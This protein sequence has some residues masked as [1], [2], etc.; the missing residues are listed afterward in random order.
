VFTSDRLPAASI[1]VASNVG[2]QFNKGLAISSSQA[3]A[4]TRQSWN[5]P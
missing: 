1:V 2:W 3:R 5:V 4:A